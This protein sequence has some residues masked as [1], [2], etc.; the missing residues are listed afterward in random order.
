MSD[1][2]KRLA[3]LARD[4][5]ATATK[6]EKL[7]ESYLTEGVALGRSSG[8]ADLGDRLNK[9]RLASEL[10]TAVVLSLPT[11]KL[12]AYQAIQTQARSRGVRLFGLDKPLVERLPK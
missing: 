2:E 8:A 10:K 3:K 1:Q 12:D 9:R 6:L 11:L 4:V 5:L 7:C